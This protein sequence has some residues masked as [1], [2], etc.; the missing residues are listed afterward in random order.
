MT[1]ILKAKDI[2]EAKTHELKERCQK[3]QALGIQPCMKVFLVGNNPASALYT[4]NKKKFCEKIGASCDI[5]KL[6]EDISAK[7]FEQ[8]VREV[9]ANPKVH[10][11]FI[12][13]PLPSHLNH[14]KIET[15]ISPKKD[16]DGFSPENIF[17]L[18]HGDTGQEALI[19]CTPKGIITLLQH[20]K[21]EIESKNVLVIGR[22]MIVGR[23]LCYL[24]TNLNA[25]VTLAHART[26][27]LPEL[28]RKADIV[29]SAVGKPRFLNQSYFD[30]T[31]STVVVDVGI[32]HD[33][34][35]QLCGDVD[36]EVVK[37]LVF[38]ITPVP[39]GVGPMTILSLIDNFLTATQRSIK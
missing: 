31:K 17:K 14:L 13:L 4:K 34:N 8:K 29:V 32:N 27:N 10:A 20:Y 36:F 33:E 7:E 6:P 1:T 2:V 25:T 38:A 35:D 18:V 26:K 39:G 3:L 11:C 21:I 12:Q 15:F 24:L 28:C 19:P 9:D 23:P 30:K 5:I 16:V 37:E 22:S